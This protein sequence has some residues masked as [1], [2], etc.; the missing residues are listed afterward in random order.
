MIAYTSLGTN[1]LG[2]SAAFY[3]TIL[4]K[5]GAKRVMEFDDFIVWSTGEGSPGFSVHIPENGKPSTVGNGVMIALQAQSPE[6]IR[7]IHASA[8]ELGAINEGD[9]GPRG[10]SGFFAAYFRDLDGNKLNVHCMTT[11]G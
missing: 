5:L 2:K 7:V 3:D 4:S 9:P 8:L 10:E 11:S 1:D 6:H